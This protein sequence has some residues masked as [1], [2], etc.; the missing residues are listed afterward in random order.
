VGRHLL[1][2]VAREA[3]VV[4]VEI[5]AL[6]DV[7]FDCWMLQILIVGKYTETGGH[8]C[9]CDYVL[10]KSCFARTYVMWGACAMI[11]SSVI[12]QLLVDCMDTI[13]VRDHVF[14][15]TM[16]RDGDVDLELSVARSVD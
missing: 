13:T 4:A 3:R 2:V 15:H 12:T 11:S 7:G 8:H 1:S 14:Y 16:D 9:F 10:S 6:I 5:D